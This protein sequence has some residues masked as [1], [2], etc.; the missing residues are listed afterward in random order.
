MRVRVKILWYRSRAGNALLRCRFGTFQCRHNA[1]GFIRRSIRIQLGILRVEWF[2]GMWLKLRENSIFCSVIIVILW[3]HRGAK[4]RRF[5]AAAW[6]IGFE[7]PTGRVA[8]YHK[9]DSARLFIVHAAINMHFILI[10][11]YFVLNARSRMNY[12]HLEG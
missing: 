11:L 12:N 1:S 10:P 9:W 2:D 3:S 8:L 7:W 4:I 6:E 5:E